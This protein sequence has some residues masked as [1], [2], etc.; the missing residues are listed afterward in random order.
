M[1]RGYRR[2]L[3]RRCIRGIIV[4]EFGQELNEGSTMI[5]I[6]HDLIAMNRPLTMQR[7]RRGCAGRMKKHIGQLR[8]FQ[9]ML[10]LKHTKTKKN[11]KTQTQYRQKA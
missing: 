4:N 6:G 10:F 11:T 9:H 1:L 5:A 7:G 8:P 2:C 3:G